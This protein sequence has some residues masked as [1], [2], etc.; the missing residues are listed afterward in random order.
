[1]KTFILSQFNYCPLVWM[2]CDRTLDNTINRIHENALR[3]VSQNK[4]ADL[5][6]LLL[7]SNSASIHKRNLQLVIIEVY[8][9]LQNIH[10][11]FM[12]EIF[13]QKDI[14]HNLRNNLLMRIPKMR[15]SSYGIERLY[16]LG[17]RLW[18]NLPDEFKSIKTLASFKRQIKGWNDNC[19]CRLCRQFISDFGFL[20]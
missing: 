4:I 6:T 12:K 14:T 8:K 13:V 17:C 2:F 7:E 16:F 20:N 3:I 5:N 18:N 15:T 19:N 9:T 10:P 11:S 1:M